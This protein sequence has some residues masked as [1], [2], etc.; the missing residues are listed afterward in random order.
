GDGD[1]RITQGFWEDGVDT[2]SFGAGI[3]PGDLVLTREASN[4]SN[5]RISFT[6][7]SGSILLQGQSDGRA[8]G[9]EQI[10]F[11][12]GTIWDRAALDA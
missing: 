1:D 10:Q 11:A 4:G 6:D 5:V 9:I 8:T 2:L 7:H 3:T 12:D